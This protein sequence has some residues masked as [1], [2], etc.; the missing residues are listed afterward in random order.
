MIYE[1]SAIPLALKPRFS[2]QKIAWII[3][4]DRD[5]LYITG[6]AIEMGKKWSIA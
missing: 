2:R 4:H 1:I 3:L 6:P 5:N